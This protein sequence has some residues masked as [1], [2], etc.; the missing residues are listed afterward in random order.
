MRDCI[1]GKTQEGMN[2]HSGELWSDYL[3]NKIMFHSFDLFILL[4]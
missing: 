4:F 3:E 2:S 1:T